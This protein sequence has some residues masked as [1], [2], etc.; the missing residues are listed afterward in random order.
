MFNRLK[1]YLMI[2]TGRHH[3][4]RALKLSFVQRIKQA[5][6]VFKILGFKNLKPIKIFP[7]KEE[8]ENVISSHSVD[9]Q[10]YALYS[11]FKIQEIENDSH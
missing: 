4:C 7:V 11:I 10:R 1:M 2:L 6:Y 5:L 3:A 8:A 9:A